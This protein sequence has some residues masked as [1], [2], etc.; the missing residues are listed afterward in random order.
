MILLS[1]D[2]IL[3]E[4]YIRSTVDDFTL[5]WLCLCLVVK[6]YAMKLLSTLTPRVN[7]KFHVDVKSQ[8]GGLC[9][10]IPATFHCYMLS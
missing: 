3:V 9:S 4:L 2:C 6:I 5:L 7:C 10:G 8:Y 1:C